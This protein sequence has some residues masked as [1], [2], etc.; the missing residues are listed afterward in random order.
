[1]ENVDLEQSLRM[2]AYNSRLQRS[3]EVAN[4]PKKKVN[5]R[6]RVHDW[7]I[8]VLRIVACFAG[9]EVPC[10]DVERCSELDIGWMICRSYLSR[11]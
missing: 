5:I 4:I 11:R 6:G 10:G 3:H 1:M 2:W 9:L 7:M 8:K